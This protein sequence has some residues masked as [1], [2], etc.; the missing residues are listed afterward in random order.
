MGDIGDRGSVDFVC[1]REM[2]MSKE[3]IKLPHLGETFSN[4]T[5]HIQVFFFF[6][7]LHHV[8]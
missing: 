8:L 6:I 5:L 1:E 2:G 3:A 4:C 7:D